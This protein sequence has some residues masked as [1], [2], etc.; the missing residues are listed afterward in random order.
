MPRR[1]SRFRPQ[2]LATPRH[3]HR[4]VADRSLGGRPTPLHPP[5]PRI[6]LMSLLSPAH[7]RAVALP[8]FTSLLRLGFLGCGHPASESECRDLAQHIAKLRLQARGFDAAEIGRR[9]AQAEQD[10][11]YKKTMEGCVGKRITEESLACVKNATSPEEIKLKC[12]R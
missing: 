9:L 2:P 10:P 4:E 5:S 11:E 6:S 7:T 12:A 3:V 1:G 8:V